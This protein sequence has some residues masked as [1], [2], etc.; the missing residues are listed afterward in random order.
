MQLSLQ[1]R[2]QTDA[3]GSSA[4]MNTTCA[5]ISN[6]CVIQG[7]ALVACLG[8]CYRFVSPLNG[9]TVL[10]MAP[11]PLQHYTC[12]ETKLSTALLSAFWSSPGER[13]TTHPIE[14]VTQD[15][16]QDIPPH[17]VLVPVWPQ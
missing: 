16:S 13:G 5:A 4:V 7:Q 2:H 14:E 8:F 9:C 10:C 11:H 12:L 15:P 1:Q 17:C 3:R 6:L